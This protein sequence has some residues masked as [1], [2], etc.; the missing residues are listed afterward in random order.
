MSEG[1]RREGGGE[2]GEEGDFGITFSQLRHSGRTCVQALGL[3]GTQAD[4]QLLDFQH[5]LLT[6]RGAMAC[7][8]EEIPMTGENVT[9]DCASAGTHI[10]S[11]GRGQETE[12]SEFCKH[13]PC[14]LLGDTGDMLNSQWNS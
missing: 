1:G 6:Q 3:I 11:L 8:Q 10:G 4:Q 12:L 5:I 13:G 7:Q 9:E 2:G 14:T